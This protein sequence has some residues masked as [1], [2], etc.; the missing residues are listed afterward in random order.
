MRTDTFV[1]LRSPNYR[2]G[3]FDEIGQ[4]ISGASGRR[5]FID[6]SAA[7]MKLPLLLPAAYAFS[8]YVLRDNEAYII[9]IAAMALAGWLW[10]KV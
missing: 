2:F 9:G 4:K 7:L 3:N 1:A 8:R 6:Q 10:R 5:R